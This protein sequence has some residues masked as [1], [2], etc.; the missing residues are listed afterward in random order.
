MRMHNG[1][2][3]SSWFSRSAG[4]SVRKQNGESRKREPIDTREHGQYPI[5]LFVAPRV[6]AWQRWHCVKQCAFLVSVCVCVCVYSPHKRE[7]SYSS[8]YSRYWQHVNGPSIH[9]TQPNSTGQRMKKAQKCH[10]PSSVWGH[11]HSFIQHHPGARITNKKEEE[12]KLLT[13]GKKKRTTQSRSAW[14]SQSS[15][16]IISE[17]EEV[18]L[19]LFY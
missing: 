9:W 2:F 4:R 6:S 5:S 12:E 10:F 19:G 14:T 1:S 17:E 3:I 7:P 11:I 8:F 18:F 16:T 13:L 15:R